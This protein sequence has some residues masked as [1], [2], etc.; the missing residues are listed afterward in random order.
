MAAARLSPVVGLRGRR[1]GTHERP[2]LM[3]QRRPK[4]HL[5]NFEGRVMMIQSGG[6]TQE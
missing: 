3:N 2:I 5:Q 1:W 6:I 4:I